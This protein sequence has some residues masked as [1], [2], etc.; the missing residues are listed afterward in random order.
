MRYSSSR[1][2]TSKTTRRRFKTKK[3]PKV[4]PAKSAMNFNQF[5]QIQ[6]QPR[7]S[8]KTP[9]KKRKIKVRKKRWVSCKRGTSSYKKAQSNKIYS[10]Y[11]NR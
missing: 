3:V 2:Y 8:E 9:K 6:P 7:P 5:T 1:L 10:I 4:N 11:K